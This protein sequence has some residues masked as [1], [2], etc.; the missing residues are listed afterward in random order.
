MKSLIDQQAKILENLEKRTFIYH[1]NP[2]VFRPLILQAENEEKYKFFGNI[3]Y[4][5]PDLKN[6]G[7]SNDFYHPIP[8]TGQ[9]DLKNSLISKETICQDSTIYSFKITIKDVPADKV[10]KAFIGVCT[11]YLA[12]E[13]DS[14]GNEKETKI[15]SFKLI[16]PNTVE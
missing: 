5:K 13:K 1:Y 10:S 2:G 14:F 7:Y 16:A 6:K 15:Q 8:T 9:I 11:K 4:R 12:A 3:L